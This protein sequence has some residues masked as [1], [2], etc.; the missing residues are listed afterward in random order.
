MLF[1]VST[2]LDE[3]RARIRCDHT[4]YSSISTP[5]STIP[6][7]F[8]ICRQKLKQELRTATRIPKRVSLLKVAEITVSHVGA[9][10]YRWKRKCH[11]IR[12]HR[13][14]HPHEHFI[15]IRIE[16]TDN[17]QYLNDAR[18]DDTMST[19]QGDSA[20]QSY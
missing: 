3:L 1:S 8:T 4:Y 9:H 17:T 12:R 10:Q 19:H 11:R 7:D 6:N 18:L 16:S 14:Y 5:R 20:H 13:W 15:C 2:Q